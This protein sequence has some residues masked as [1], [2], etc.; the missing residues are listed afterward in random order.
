MVCATKTSLMWSQDSQVGQS[1]FILGIDNLVRA[2]YT[3][4][5]T[6]LGFKLELSCSYFNLT[7]FPIW[8]GLSH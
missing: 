3:I 1:S 2:Q 4:S 5:L 7:L 6:V 8:D